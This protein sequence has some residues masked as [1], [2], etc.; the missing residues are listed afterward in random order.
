MSVD[1]VSWIC[2]LEDYANLNP[3]CLFEFL[4]LNRL[5]LCCT[6]GYVS[7]LSACI[8]LFNYHCAVYFNNTVNTQLAFLQRISQTL[9]HV[10]GK[11]PVL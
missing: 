2:N 3:H 7:L 6:Q 5:N 9:V 11:Y 8:L 1:S 4:L 10:G